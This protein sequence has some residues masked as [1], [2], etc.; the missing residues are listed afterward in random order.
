MASNALLFDTAT[1]TGTAGLFVAPTTL[2]SLYVSADLATP[3]PT[4]LMGPA[5]AASTQ[6]SS[7]AGIAIAI[8]VVVIVLV[9][10]SSSRDGD[11]TIKVGIAIF[12]LIRPSIRTAGLGWGIDRYKSP[13]RHG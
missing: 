1:A 13:S 5:D 2:S 6:S 8:A 10:V 11:S 3:V 12:N 7:G 9:L 4:A